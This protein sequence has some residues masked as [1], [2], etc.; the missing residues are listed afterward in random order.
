[1]KMGVA[2][3]FHGSENG[4]E[5]E[6]DIVCANEACIVSWTQGQE[7]F[8]YSDTENRCTKPDPFFLYFFCFPEVRLTEACSHFMANS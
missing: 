5:G 2:I 4:K 8:L 6:A 7:T 3:Q 1:M